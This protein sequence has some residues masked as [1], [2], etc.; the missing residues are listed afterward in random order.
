MATFCFECKRKIGTFGA[1]ETKKMIISS[2]GFPPEN[3]GEKDVLC[4]DCL[5]PIR[6]SMEPMK[7]LGQTCYLCKGK[8]S[9]FGA[10]KISIKNIQFHKLQL[11]EGMREEDRICRSCFRNR[12]GD[13]E[14]IMKENEIQD[15]EKRDQWAEEYKKSQA[16]INERKKEETQ[17][18]I[19]RA[20]IYKKD[21]N[22]NGI[23]QFKNERIAILRRGWGSQVEFIVAYDDLTNEGYR[24]MAIDEGKEASTGGLTGGVNAYFYFQK[25]EY[26]R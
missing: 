13:M 24:L 16:E 11:P 25:M 18:L 1:R 15:K 14:K 19:N 4:D 26:V 6:K 3:M 8:V 5:E 9:T 17:D 20:E 2:G 23:I 21:W 7:T 12:Y 10:G 22:K